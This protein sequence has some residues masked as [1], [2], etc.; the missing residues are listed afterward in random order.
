M[1]R[2]LVLLAALATTPAFA[3]PAAFAPDS[4]EAR[5]R[6]LHAAFDAPGLAVAVVRDGQVVLAR[7]YG[8]REQGRPEPVTARTLFYTSSVTKSFTVLALGLLADQGRLRIDDPVTKYLPAF[9]AG[10]SALTR[11]LTLRDLL[12][13]RTGLP[14]AD[15][16][17]LGGYDARETLERTGRLAPI[18]PLR[19]RLTYSNQMY[20]AA[21]EIVSAVAGRPYADFMEERVLRPLGMTSS[22]AR[23]IGA[24]AANGDQ[25]TPHARIEGAVRTFA[26]AVRAP[27]GAGA[28]NASA[29]DLARYLRMLLAEGRVD[30][31]RFVTPAVAQAPQQPQ[32]VAAPLATTPDATLVSYGL[33]WFLHDYHGVK[34][35][36][37]GG[38]AE[39]WTALVGLI[40]GERTGVAVLVNMNQSALPYAVFYSIVDAALGRAARDWGGEF[41]AV[42]KRMR[43]ADAPPDTGR[44]AEPARLAG[45]Y[46]H[47]C[48]G[49]FDVSESSGRLIARYGTESARLVPLG[50]EVFGVRWETPSLRVLAPTA[51]LTFAPSSLSLDVGTGPIA[52]TREGAGPAR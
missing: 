35:V 12:A 3:A 45:H 5:V 25:A 14:R 18:A 7:G 49:S 52:F 8:V 13:H 34:V 44:I 41:L 47:P 27:Y 46:V 42:E 26:P 43:P 32:I 28:V 4:L 40:P 9:R 16:L 37:H 20:L 50:A 33:G 23:G 6:A 24:R 29:D 38:N 17:M 22:N 19:T 21:G 1:I 48:Y 36:Q 10:D 15:L 39:G 51:R 31:A 2:A 30:T 11:Q